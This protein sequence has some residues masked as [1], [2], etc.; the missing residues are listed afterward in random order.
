MHSA[1]G[2]RVQDLCRST[3]QRVGKSDESGLIQGSLSCPSP[4]SSISVGFAVF[5]QL[6][7][8]SNTD[9]QTDHVTL[10]I[11]EGKSHIHTLRAQGRF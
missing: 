8:V 4:E 7:H 6:I 3:L 9:E 10:D 2:G 5:P 1:C 11:C